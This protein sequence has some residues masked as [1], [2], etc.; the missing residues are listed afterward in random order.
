MKHGVFKLP[1]KIFHPLY[2]KAHRAVRAV[3]VMIRLN[4]NNGFRKERNR[5]KTKTNA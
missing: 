5:D 2:H 1:K 3:A 4:G